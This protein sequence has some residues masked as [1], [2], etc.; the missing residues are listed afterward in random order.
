MNEHLTA[1]AAMVPGRVFTEPP[2]SPEVLSV[3]LFPYTVVAV[4]GGRVTPDRYTITP[5]RSDF[6]V[7]TVVVGLTVAQAQAARERVVAAL[8]FAHPAVPGR[9]TS[10]IEH[11]ASAPAARDTDVPD[12]V[13]VVA[14]DNWTFRSR[15]AA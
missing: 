11:V 13:V 14:A 7:R 3:S 6:T 9:V 10:R 8:A 1:L 5:D 15:T 12:R 2:K 4:D